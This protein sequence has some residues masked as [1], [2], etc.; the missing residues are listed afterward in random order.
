MSCLPELHLAFLELGALLAR[1]SAWE[2]NPRSIGVTK[3]LGYEDDG[4]SLE[5]RG[6]AAVRHLEFRL[7]R[8]RFEAH[9]RV[10]VTVEGI[11]ACRELFGPVPEPPPV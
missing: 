3:S 11:E 6:D 8:A 5:R 2:D 9:R 7:E 1:T 4:W 10:E